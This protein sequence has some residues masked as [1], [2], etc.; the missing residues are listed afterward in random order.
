[1]NLRM[2]KLFTHL[3]I[4]LALL[5][6]AATAT[7]AAGHKH[8]DE[9]KTAIIIAGFGTTVPRA[10]GAVTNINDRVRQAFPETEVRLTFT[11]NIIRSIWGKR[12]AEA[13]KWL[14]QGVPEE[15]LYVENIISVIGDLREEGYRNIIVQPTH[16][17]YMEQSHDLN[18]YVRAFASIN[19]MKTR[20]RPF[21]KVVMGRP[22]LGMPGDRYSY[23]DD[24]ATVVQTLA[25]DAEQARREDAVLVYMGHGNEHWSTGIYAE[26]QKKM[27]EEYPDVETVIGVVEGN[28]TIDDVLE[29]LKTTKRKK[30]IL[31]PF[32]I[33]AG[34]HAVNDMA[35]PEEDSWLSLLQKNG[36]EVETVLEGLGRNNAFADIFVNH[37]KD[38]AADHNLELR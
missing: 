5:S 6:L 24:I 11:S 12:R 4:T 33:V 3:L 28:P 8:N 25:A 16:M 13:Q 18:S 31:K 23:H 17:F 10:L 34:D 27:K 35:G 1:M 38:V 9:A 22:A 2:R 20:W 15:I 19:T 29:Q 30:V 7:A 37:I 21:D 26:T 32:M 36:Y 14:D